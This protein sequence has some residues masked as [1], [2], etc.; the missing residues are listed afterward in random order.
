MYFVSGRK[1]KKK[2]SK[3]EQVTL[4]SGKKLTEV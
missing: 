3:L 4:K 2:Q 1:L